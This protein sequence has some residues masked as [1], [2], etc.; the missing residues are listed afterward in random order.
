MIEIYMEYMA[1]GS[2]SSMIK[3]YGK[4]NEEVIQ[5]FVI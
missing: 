3:Q 5:K 2:I 1:G 4:F